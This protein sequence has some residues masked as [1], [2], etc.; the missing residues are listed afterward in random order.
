MLP[1]FKIEAILL[2]ILEMHRT[3]TTAENDLA[4]NISSAMIADLCSPGPLH[5]RCASE[6][7]CTLSSDFQLIS[8]G[9]KYELLSLLGHSTQ[10]I[11]GYRGD[12]TAL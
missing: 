1:S 3:A 4:Q 11:A 8:A 6:S 9:P 10:D 5:H 7:T 12:Y 2:N